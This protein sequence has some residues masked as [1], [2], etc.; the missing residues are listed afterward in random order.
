MTSDKPQIYQNLTAELAALLAGETDRMANAANMAA[1]IRHGLSDLNW[2]GFYFRRGGELV[3]GPFQGK[4]A[5]IRIP[6]G[7]GVCG[8]AAA[9]GLSVLVPDVHEFPGHIACDPDSRSELVVPLVEDGIVAGVLDLDSPLLARFDEADLQGC[10]R[11]VGVFVAHH[12][13]APLTAED[14]DPESGCRLPLPRREDL[15]AAG[16][17]TYDRLADPAGGTLRGLKGP[18]GIQLHSPELSRRS[19]PVNHYLRY[20]SGLGGRVRELAILA[21][22]RELDS[23][24]EWAAHEPAAIDEGIARDIVDLVRYRSD[25]SGLDK[26]DAA[27]IELS[28][29]IFGARRVR[30]ATFARALRLF[31][32]RKLVDLVA[33]MGNYAATAALLTAFDMQLDPDGPQLWLLP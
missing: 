23:A 26:A 21:T 17:E 13:R 15:D 1:L 5:C 14:I 29:E 31:G 30:P 12:R 2:A 11:L 4:P 6:V 27:V 25:T 20:E 24:F 16:Q 3:L 18:G 33:L 9:R 19:R 32:R 22:A 7:E 10:E 8:T 28:R